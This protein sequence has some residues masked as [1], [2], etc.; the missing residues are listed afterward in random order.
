MKPDTAHTQASDAAHVPSRLRVDL[1]SGALVRHA[2]GIFRI[3]EILDFTTVV[4]T[5]V[6]TGRTKVLRV[7]ELMPVESSQPPT[8]SAVDIDS[9]AEDDWRVA[10]TRYDAIRPLLDSPDQSRSAV[11]ARAAEV[12]VDPA[13][14]YRW[15]G[16][17]RA[18]D[19]I[20]ALIPFKR[21]WKV[22]NYRIGDAAEGVIR[23]V[24]KDFYLKP[25]RPS[26]QKVV[27]E[28][29]RICDERH[30]ERP[31]PTA[32]RSRIDRIPEHER[33]KRRGQAE[34]A[35]NKFHPVPGK[36]PGADYPLAVVQ[37]DHTPV[38]VILVDDVHRKPIDRP[39][40]TVAIDVFSRMTVGYYLSFDEPSTTSVA[41]CLSHAMLPKDE[42]LLLHDVDGT[43]PVWGRPHKVHVDNGPDFR[44]KSLRQSCK[45]HAVDIEFRPVKVPRY[46][47]HIERLQGTLLR[48][49][50]DLPGTTFSS[51][52][53]RGDYDSEK[54]AV[55]TKDEFEKLFVD[56]ICNT[57]HRRPHS[58]LGMP[59][60]RMWE[61]GIFGGAGIQGVGMPPRPADRLTVVL[62]FLPSFSRTVQPD[63]VSLD[64]LRY[65]AEALRPWIG[66]KDADT[67][68]A[69][70]HVFRRDPRDVSSLWFY[71]P[72][73]KQYFKVP[74]ADQSAPAF[75]IWE[76]QLAKAALAKAGHDPSDERAVFKSIGDRRA[77]VE[78]SA[79]RTKKARREAQR[80]K[81]HA[82]GRSPA[83]PAGKPAAAG[84]ASPAPTLKP[85]GLLSN[86]LTSVDATDDIA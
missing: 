79:S 36:F 8:A 59:P 26:P 2:D 81:D 22:G 54:Q 70:Q 37:I 82:K 44:S 5:A 71:D 14:L 48:E 19:A 60:L 62:D 47:G 49:I 1:R 65:Y 39:W 32:I 55:M 76:H 53:E 73:L 3:S 25:E 10:Q 43:W 28:V 11:V 52:K 30:V 69:R 51:I 15:L 77:I 84:R 58:A 12:E 75:S 45:M 29:H 83:A 63:G 56:L 18:L 50:H 64:G 6:E 86:L 23:A 27:R 17:Y 9:I 35:R 68:K 31:S 78:E 67:G 46:G 33:L 72:D 61:F 80:Q 4:A 74:L 57:Y 38:D 21:G 13:T 34:L 42:W 24:I 66:M 40:V 16:R 7:G 85:A 41:M 20:S